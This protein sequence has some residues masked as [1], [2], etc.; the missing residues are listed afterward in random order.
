MHEK[1]IKQK[2]TTQ[3]IKAKI[4]KAALSSKDAKTTPASNDVIVI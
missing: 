1:T 2:K 3:I 4:K